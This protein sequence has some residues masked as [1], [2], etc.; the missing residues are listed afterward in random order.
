MLD[1]FFLKFEGE[2]GQI[3]PLPPGK[4]TTFKKP[5]LIEINR[6]IMNKIIR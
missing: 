4:R 5:S 3:D 6:E 2:E 1:K